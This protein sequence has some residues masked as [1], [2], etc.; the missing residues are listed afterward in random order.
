[1]AKRKIELEVEY[2]DCA[3]CGRD[4]GE[5]EYISLGL[6]LGKKH[7]NKYGDQ[8]PTRLYTGDLFVCMSCA[9]KS[10]KVNQQL[11]ALVEST[12]RKMTQGGY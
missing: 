8:M 4:L 10:A 7:R 5:D 12:M 1:M 6:E 11:V 3:I 2:P 9:T